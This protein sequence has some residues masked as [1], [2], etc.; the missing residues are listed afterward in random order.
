MLEKYE[1]RSLLIACPRCRD[2]RM[3]IEPELTYIFDD[4]NKFG[5]AVI[6]C[7]HCCKYFLIREEDDDG[8]F[9]TT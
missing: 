9:V 2:K 5:K 8:P 7:D 1:E 3:V 6:W 4:L